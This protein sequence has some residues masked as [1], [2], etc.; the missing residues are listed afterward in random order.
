MKKT[1]IDTTSDEKNNDYRV[2]E[3]ISD[4]STNISDEKINVSKVMK[5]T[6]YCL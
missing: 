6:R 1:S 4:V 3:K 5:Y 2:L